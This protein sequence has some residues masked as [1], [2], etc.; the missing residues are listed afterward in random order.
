MPICKSVEGQ[1]VIH[2]FQPQHPDFARAGLSPPPSL[3]LG[4]FSCFWSTA[5][6]C[7][8]LETLTAPKSKKSNQIIPPTSTQQPVCFSSLAARVPG[9]LLE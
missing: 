9:F 4:I 3:L 5:W 2:Y 7:G 1:L 6:L 8:H